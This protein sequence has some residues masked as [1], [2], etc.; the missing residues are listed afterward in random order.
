MG[1]RVPSLRIGGLVAPAPR[2]RPDCGN[3]FHI[4]LQ[5]TPGEP[6]YAEEQCVGVPAQLPKCKTG[7]L[8][9][10]TSS[11]RLCMSPAVLQSARERP[12]GLQRRH[13]APGL[14]WPGGRPECELLGQCNSTSFKSRCRAA[15]A[16]VETPAAAGGPLPPSLLL[17][18]RQAC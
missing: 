5:T 15:E 1:P 16:A 11:P 17:H 7:I 4:N 10:H 13:Q 12:R 6:S 14:E 18:H 3:G 8:R 2:W 9:A